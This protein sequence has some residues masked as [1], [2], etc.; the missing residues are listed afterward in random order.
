[1]VYGIAS[2]PRLTH[3]SL[4]ACPKFPVRVSREF[5]S[6]L[7]AVL[8]LS[9]LQAPVYAGTVPNSLYF[10][11]EQGTWSGDR[12]APDCV[13]SHAPL[14]NRPLRLDVDCAR[15]FKGLRARP[16]SPAEIPAPVLGLCS[17]IFSALTGD[18]SAGLNAPFLETSS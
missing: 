14:Q 10:P 3:C 8:A 12:F 9:R 11:A 6:N 15:G 18:F 7:L 4:F 5:A 16:R 1:M 17:R 13:L 2:A